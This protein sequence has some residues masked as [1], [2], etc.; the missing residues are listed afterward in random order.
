MPHGDS[1]IR[2]VRVVP[3]PA[4]GLVSSRLPPSADAPHGEVASAL[5][6]AGAPG[7]SIKDSWQGALSLRASG[8]SDVNYDDVF[9]ADEFVVERRPRA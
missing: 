4:R 1:G 2:A 3:S 5:I 8:N 6:R 9:V 7:L